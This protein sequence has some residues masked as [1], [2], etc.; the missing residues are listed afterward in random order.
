MCYSGGYPGNAKRGRLHCA[1][2]DRVSVAIVLGQL[3]AEGAEY[4]C[5][6]EVIT[7]IPKRAAHGLPNH[8]AFLH[9]ILTF[10]ARTLPKACYSNMQAF[11]A[12]EF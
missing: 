4:R 11:A 5:S 6:P 12:T 2:G 10:V 8:L 7:T 9:Y 1:K 3:G